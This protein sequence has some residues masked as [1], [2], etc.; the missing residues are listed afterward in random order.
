MNKYTAI[1]FFNYLN[2]IRGG[3][4]LNL[5][6][7]FVVVLLSIYLYTLDSMHSMHIVIFVSLY[8]TLGNLNG[9]NRNITLTELTKYPV[10]I[11]AII[12]MLSV[13]YLASTFTIGLLVYILLR[14]THAVAFIEWASVL[15]LAAYGSLLGYLVIQLLIRKMTDIDILF[16]L[17][18]ALIHMA[19]ISSALLFFRISI[20]GTIGIYLLFITFFHIVAV[21]NIA[22]ILNDNIEDLLER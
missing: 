8:I 15:L 17:L 20:I 4:F 19:F 3:V 1:L 21:R 22:A 12:H 2:R 16:L 6:S 10:T 5:L 18:M 11:S 9:I 13:K 14:I 7:L